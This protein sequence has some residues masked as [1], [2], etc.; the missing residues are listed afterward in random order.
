M[1]TK[2]RIHTTFFTELG[3]REMHRTI[4]LTFKIFGESPSWL[5]TWTS[6]CQPHYELCHSG[7]W[8]CWLFMCTDVTWSRHREQI[9]T[10]RMSHSLLRPEFLSPRLEA[11]SI[12][13]LT[14]HWS[15]WQLMPTRFSGG[16][17]FF[18]ICGM[19]VIETKTMQLQRIMLLV[20]CFFGHFF[21]FFCNRKNNIFFFLFQYDLAPITCM[22]SFPITPPHTLGILASCWSSNIPRMVKSQGLF[23]CHPLELLTPDA[24]IVKICSL[25]FCWAYAQKSPYWRQFPRLPV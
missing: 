8:V 11:I 7:Q 3:S 10:E 2:R 14:S 13:W 22:I 18:G 20:A 16:G 24:F 17:L 5:K 15:R 6:K 21:F 1:M 9:Q 12:S 25:V 4:K 23:S 19:V